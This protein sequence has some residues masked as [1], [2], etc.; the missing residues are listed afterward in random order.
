LQNKT[1]DVERPM[2][3]Y[4]SEHSFGGRMGTVKNVYVEYQD[5][6]RRHHKLSAQ[7]VEIPLELCYHLHIKAPIMEHIFELDNPSVTEQDFINAGFVKDP[8]FTA[9]IEQ[10]TKRVAL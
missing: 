5:Y 8:A 9:F 3:F 7:Q 2:I 6:W 10:S 1:K 4:L